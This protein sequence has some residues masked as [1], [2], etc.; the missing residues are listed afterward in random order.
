MTFINQK[1]FSENF[2]SSASILLYHRFGENN[3]P[4]T[5]ITIEQLDK[6]IETLLNSEYNIMR[7]EN[8]ALAITRGES[9]PDKTVGISIDDAFLSVYEV[10]W[11]KFLEAKIPFTVFVSTEHIDKKYPSMMSWDQIKEMHNSG[12]TIGNHL[13]THDSMINLEPNIWKLK[14]DIAQK[15]LTEVLGEKPKLFAYPY[16]EANNEIKIFMYSKL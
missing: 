13:A 6:H 3:F 10:A 4:S 5:S 12:V 16:G 11:P 14:V 7:L 9:L 8:I 15:K 1:V 2:N